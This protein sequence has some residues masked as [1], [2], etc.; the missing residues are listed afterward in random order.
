MMPANGD[1][2]AIGAWRFQRRDTSVGSR[3]ETTAY[4]GAILPG[5]QKP[6]GVIGQLRWAPGVLGMITSGYASRANYVW[7]G[8]GAAHFDQSHGDRRPDMLMYSL[9]YGYRPKAL[10]TDYPHW[11]GRFFVEMNGENAS[12]ITHNG[13]H[14]TGTNGDQVFLGPSTLWLYKNYGVEAGIQFPVYRNTGPQFQRERYRFAINFS[15]F[16]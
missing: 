16:F 8:V 2:E 1:F 12:R 7:A 10:R 3:I 6:P 5:A 15:Y 9:V 14:V 4:A 13:L 11:D